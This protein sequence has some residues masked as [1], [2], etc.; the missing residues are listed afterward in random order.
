MRKPFCALANC[1][2]RPKGVRKKTTII[3]I[4]DTSVNDL[5]YTHCQVEVAYKFSKR[6]ANIKFVELRKIHHNVMFRVMDMNEADI[7][8]KSS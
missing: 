5:I 6:I 7:L 4:K 8:A 2:E 3:I 1:V